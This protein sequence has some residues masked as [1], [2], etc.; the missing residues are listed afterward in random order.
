MGKKRASSIRPLCDCN[1]ASRIAC[2][3]LYPVNAIMHQGLPAQLSAGM[4]LTSKSQ[5]NLLVTFVWP[6]D[7][8]TQVIVTLH[9]VFLRNCFHHFRTLLRCSLHQNVRHVESWPFYN[10]LLFETRSWAKW[11]VNTIRQQDKSS[12]LNN[13]T[14]MSLKLETSLILTLYDIFK[15][16]KLGHGQT[17]LWMW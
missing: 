10:P 13:S 11:L 5:T 14:G 12:S 7:L 1:N 8:W 16:L 15:L 17:A 4:L 2:T 9:C 3:T 6:F